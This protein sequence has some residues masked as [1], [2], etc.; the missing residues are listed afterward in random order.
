MPPDALDRSSDAAL[1]ALLEGRDDDPVAPAALGVGLA[2]VDVGELVAVEE[3]AGREVVVERVECLREVRRRRGWDWGGGE[4]RRGRL[5]RGGR[6]S[7]WV[8]E[9]GQRHVRAGCPGPGEGRRRGGGKGAGS[10]AGG[11]GLRAGGRAGE[12][13]ACDECSPGRA[14]AGVLCR[15]EVQG[16][17]PPR[18]HRLARGRPLAPLALTQT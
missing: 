13:S 8:D 17:A 10:P 2:G 7:L 14:H 9:P 18:P 11:R 12:E 5:R 6:C 3:R 4:L 15:G 16:R 1:P